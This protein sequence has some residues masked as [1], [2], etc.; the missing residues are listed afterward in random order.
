MAKKFLVIDQN[1][2]RDSHLEEILASNSDLVFV[3]PDVAI[4]EMCKSSSWKTT[5]NRSLKVLSGNPHKVYLSIGI[6]EAFRYE[7]STDF[8][9]AI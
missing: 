7:I 2:L 6:G 3:L 1:Y 4:M 9:G 5:M 8:R